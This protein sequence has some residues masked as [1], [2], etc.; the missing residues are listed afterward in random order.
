MDFLAHILWSGIIFTE[1]NIYLAGL[2]GGLPDLAAFGF[3][4]IYLPFHYR[5][6]KMTKEEAEAHWYEI[7]DHWLLKLYFWTHSLVVWGIGIGIGTLI[8]SYVGG[9]YPW[10]LF[11]GVVHILC[12]IPTHTTKDFAPAFLTPLSKY[13]FNGWSWMHK[14]F[15]IINYACIVVFLLLR[16]IQYHYI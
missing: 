6:I 10:Y 5:G 13:R 7:R 4:F 9:D 8:W 15:M 14:K 11:A 1:T 3:T 12:D 2:C 16:L